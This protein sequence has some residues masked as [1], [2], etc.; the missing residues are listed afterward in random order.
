MAN[1]RQKPKD[2]EKKGAT[3][4]PTMTLAAMERLLQ[5]IARA[6]AYR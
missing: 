5:K 3:P 2:P 6:W 1:E 4:K